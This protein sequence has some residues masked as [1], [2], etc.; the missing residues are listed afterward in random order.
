MKVKWRAHADSLIY[1]FKF[2]K[3]E[4]TYRIRFCSYVPVFIRNISEDLAN[5]TNP[6]LGQYSFFDSLA[7][8]SPYYMH[9]GTASIFLFKVANRWIFADDVTQTDGTVV[10]Y[11]EHADDR[12][13]TD[14][15]FY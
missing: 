6:I 12:C 13:P 11:I 9:D 15:G 4:I 8:G 7:D 3:N 14:E 2:K 1:L 10:G 5:D